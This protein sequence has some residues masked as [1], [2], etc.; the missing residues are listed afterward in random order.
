MFETGSEDGSEGLDAVAEGSTA[1]GLQQARSLT[2]GP[3]SPSARTAPLPRLAVTSGQP[4]LPSSPTQ[5]RCADTDDEHF[6]S[7]QAGFF[8]GAGSVTTTS[9]PPSQKQTTS[10]SPSRRPGR[11][12]LARIDTSERVKTLGLPGGHGLVPGPAVSLPT[13][14]SSVIPDEA[15]YAMPK[16]ALTAAASPSSAQ[17]KPPSLSLQTVAH[18]QAKLLPSPA[19]FR[20][21]SVPVSPEG[22]SGAERMS[23]ASCSPA[24][25]LTAAQVDREVARRESVPVVEAASNGVALPPS[26]RSIT[27]SDAPVFD[28]STVVPGFLFLGP[29]ITS[30]EEAAQLKSLGVRR[31][32]NCAAEI[33]DKGRRGPTAAAAAADDGAPRLNGARPSSGDPTAR[34]TGEVDDPDGASPESLPLGDVFDRYLKI[35][36]WDN[37]EARG[38]AGHFEQACQFLDDAR[39]HDAPVYVHCRAGK[40]RSVSV[41]IAYLIHAY[42]WSLRKAYA[43]VVERRSDVSPNIG[44][45]SCL[46]AFEEMTLS[47]KSQG[48]IETSSGADHTGDCGEAVDGDFALRHSR[49][50]MPVFPSTGSALPLP[51]SGMAET[52]S[53]ASPNGP[54]IKG[55]PARDEGPSPSGPQKAPSPPRPFEGEGLTR[56]ATVAG[57]GSLTGAGG[58]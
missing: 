43:Y 19:S 58:P 27:H 50:S 32:L 49:Q 5:G 2:R 51:P 1:A 10:L 57:L 38:V 17:M 36:M 46:M 8:A 42:K 54:A 12:S 52:A 25:A 28:V 20:D 56:R 29:D 13:S 24:A 14:S 26:H 22:L 39:L 3:T 34:L 33:S 44:F 41:V 6:R 4:V 55:G 9:S 7:A 47:Q 16:R 11:P 37:V 18:L 31:I 45:V 40:S 23:S 21:A 48:I 15:A 35:P 53:S 30:R